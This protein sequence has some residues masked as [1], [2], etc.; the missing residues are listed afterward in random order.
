MPPRGAIRQIGIDQAWDVVIVDLSGVPVAFGS[1]GTSASDDAA[2]TVGASSLTPS[3]GVVTSDSVDAGDV[4]AFAMLANRQQKVTLYDSAGVELAVGGGTQYTEDAAAAANP[5]GNAIVVVRDDAR[6]GGL[7]TTDGDNVALRG[8]NAGELY[9][10]HVDAMTVAAHAVTNAG[11]FVTQVDGAALTALQLIDDPVA[12]L[13]TTTYTEAATKGMIVGAIRRDADTTLVD[14]TNE[15][16]PLQMDANGRLKVEAFS[17]ETLPVSLASVPSHAVTN[18]GTFVTQVDGAALTALQ[19]IDD[20][21]YA[22]DVAS[23]AADKGLAILAVRRDAN[24][25]LVDTT[26]DYAN[27]Q[28]DASGSLKVAIISGAGSG[29]TSIA[30]EAAFTIGTTSLTPIGGQYNSTLDSLADGSAGIAHMT[31]KRALHVS[32]RDA[33]T[34]AELAVGGGT[35]YDEDTASADAQKLT[36]AGVTRADTA[37]SQVN[38]D[39]DRSTLIVDA[40]G[41]LHVNVGNT[42]TVGTHAVTNAAGAFVVQENGAALT[43]LQLIDDT[44]TVLGTDTYTETTSKGLTIGAVRRDADTTLVGTTNEFG[45]LQMD[46]NG[47]LKVEAFSGETLPVSG[48]VTAAQGT[49]ANLNMT[50]ASAASALTALQLIDDIVYTDDTSTHATGTSK[51]ALIMAAATPTDSAV[52]ANDIGAVAMTTDRKLHVAVMDALPAGTA[53][54]GKLTANAGVTIGAVEIAAA[55]TLATVTTVSTVTAM[56]TLTG[57]GIAHDGADSGNPHK[58]G[59]RAIS[60]EIAAVANNDRSDLITDLVGKL[61]VL[62]YANPENFVSGAITSAMTGTTTTSLLAA[63]A[64]GLRN[65]IT[66]ITVSNAHATVGTDVIIQDGSGGTTLYTIPAAAVY[67]GATLHFPVPLRQPTTATAIFCA[68]VTTGAST[69]VSASGYKGA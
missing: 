53:G 16:G 57:S 18:A 6:G 1:G 39:G 50:E 17:G 67:G 8:T 54:I 65:Y 11:T 44:V 33:T 30:D 63:P 62:P 26:G 12:T 15:V 27:L 46:A 45:P 66:Q 34:G 56:T 55:Q 7:T 64:S 37:A 36:M 51:G 10:K 35:Q 58:V 48:T 25:T 68:N 61:I 43:A 23:Q 2:F 42:V 24:T 3:G 9:V 49:A 20:A 47:R 31:V 59:G 4:G 5:V 32:L 40:S 28:V 38:T 22:E 69:K 52:N 19:L 29:G 60:A 21:V 14:T 13:G 41:R